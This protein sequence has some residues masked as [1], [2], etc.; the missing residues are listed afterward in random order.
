MKI[1]LKIIQQYGF[2]EVF[3]KV[4]DVLRKGGEV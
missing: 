4:I 3:F 1:V 2:K